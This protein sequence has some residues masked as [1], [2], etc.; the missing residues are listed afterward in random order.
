MVDDAD[1]GESPVF[2]CGL[3]AAQ[4]HA[5]GWPANRIVAK[6]LSDYAACSRIVGFDLDGSLRLVANEAKRYELSAGK[7]IDDRYSFPATDKSKC[8]TL[9]DLFK[10]YI[11]SVENNA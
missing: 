2:D 10:K 11:E 1:M 3:S 8:P 6:F 5:N 4:L 7:K 9:K